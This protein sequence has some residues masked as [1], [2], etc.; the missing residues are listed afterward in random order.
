MSAAVIDVSTLPRTAT[1]A[2]APVWWGALL[3]V[4]IES[5][6]MGLVY[7]AYV[8]VR[9]NYDVWPPSPIGDRAF[10]LA[11][12]QAA[13]LYATIPLALLGRRAAT[14]HALS[15]AR[16]YIVAATVLGAIAV[17]LRW[18]ELWALPFLWDAHAHG[19]AFW[20]ALGVHTFHL[21]VGLIENLILLALLFLG[22]IER[23]RFI[24]IEASWV[25]W[26]LVVGEWLVGFPLLYVTPILLPR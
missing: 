24:D 18:R 11:V 3:L 15:P 19:S 13:L 22:P 2:R 1:G 5:T 26:W 9:G 23:K 25:L 17:A 10:R 4:V 8:Y 20:M 21:V 7:V 6:M 12:A 16:L 14:R